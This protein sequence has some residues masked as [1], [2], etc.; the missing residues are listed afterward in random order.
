MVKLGGRGYREMEA[1]GKWLEQQKMSTKWERGE[2]RREEN[3]VWVSLTP[4]VY[5]VFT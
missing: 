4:T 3:V 1:L 2:G 5:K